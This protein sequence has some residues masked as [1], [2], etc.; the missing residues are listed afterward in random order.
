M[1]SY[2]HR[3]LEYKRWIPFSVF[4]LCN[5]IISRMLHKRN[6]TAYNPLRL[7]FPTRPSSCLPLFLKP[8]HTL[9]PCLR[10][11]AAINFS[12]ALYQAPPMSTAPA[13]SPAS[14]PHL[15][16]APVRWTVPRQVWALIRESVKSQKQKPARNA[17]SSNPS[18]VTWDLNWFRADI[19]T[20]WEGYIC[21]YGT[22]KLLSNPM[23][24]IQFNH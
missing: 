5:C 17:Q 20:P 22:L 3:F 9:P 10:K 14:S 7:T 13:P 8:F 15:P 18:H 16:P 6:H 12:N 24:P 2:T 11:G 4:H 21:F 19:N 23:T 1:Q